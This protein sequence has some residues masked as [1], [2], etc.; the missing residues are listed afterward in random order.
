M[1]CGQPQPAA[2]G[3]AAVINPTLQIVE[4]N[5]PQEAEE[6]AEHDQIGDRGGVVKQIG[7]WTHAIISD[8]ERC[9][10]RVADDGNDA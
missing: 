5:V 7:G 1:V 8:Q 4:K 2:V 6:E 3:T 10:D 9:P